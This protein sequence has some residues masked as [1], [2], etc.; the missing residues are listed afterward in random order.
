MNIER[1]L[2]RLLVLVTVGLV[3]VMAGFHVLVSEPLVACTYM[4]ILAD[5]TLV[6]ITA[7]RGT[8][9]EGIHTEARRLHPET[10]NPVVL[11]PL[12][13]D[14]KKDTA[15]RS[16]DAPAVPESCAEREQAFS[17]LARYA[18]AVV[19]GTTIA[20]PIAAV[21]WVAFF[22]LRWVARGFKSAA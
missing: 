8:A 13:G 10:K 2:R 4:V 12:T 17:R 18:Y 9:P 20:L 22:A 7:P 15:P 1:G 11:E 21:L 16:P 3:L 5:G 19:A 14:L 6:R